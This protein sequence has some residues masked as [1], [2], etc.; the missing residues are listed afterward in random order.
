M[1]TVVEPWLALGAYHTSLSTSLLMLEHAPPALL[2]ALPIVSVMPVT[3]GPPLFVERCRVR[4]L[5]PLIVSGMEV[6]VLT[7]F[8]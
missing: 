6:K 3:A 8:R 2:Q 1:V 5:P 4:R 7:P